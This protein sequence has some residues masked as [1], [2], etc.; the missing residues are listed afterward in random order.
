[1]HTFH[2]E[3]TCNVNIS[4]NLS[5]DFDAIARITAAQ[6]KSRYLYKKHIQS[7][8]LHVTNLSLSAIECKWR[9]IRFGVAC[10]SGWRGWCVC[11]GGMR[12]VLA[13]VAC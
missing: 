12:G 13:W 2:G 3:R 5:K 6:M 10:Y 8:Y 4:S 1:M 7:R 11:V 9:A